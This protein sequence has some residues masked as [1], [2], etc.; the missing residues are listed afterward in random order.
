MEPFFLFSGFLLLAVTLFKSVYTKHWRS[1]QIYL[2]L[3]L[4]S[5]LH[6]SLTLTLLASGKIFDFPHF[7]RTGSIATYFFIPAS[8]LFV[9]K[10]IGKDKFRYT[11]LLFFIP[12]VIYLADMSRFISSDE[13]Y[14]YAQV[15]EDAKTGNLNGFRQSVFMPL[16]FHYYF[17][18]LF[19]VILSI[20]QIIFISKQLRRGGTEFFKENQKLVLWFYAWALMLMITCLPDLIMYLSGKQS[21]VLNY[22]YVSPFIFITYAYPISLLISPAVFNGIKGEW[23]EMQA[24]SGKKYRY[25]S[26][27]YL[28][29]SN[30]F[31][32]TKSAMD[33][34][35][36]AKSIT[37]SEYSNSDEQSN[38]RQNTKIYYS[39]EKAEILKNQIDQYMITM[40]PYL[41]IDYSINKLAVDTQLSVRQVSSLLNNYCNTSFKDYINGFRVKHFINKY[42]NEADSVKMTMEGL[43]KDSGFSNRYT[44]IHA[45]KKQMGL[46]PSEY[47]NRKTEEDADSKEQVSSAI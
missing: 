30:L 39:I 18:C 44:F 16:Q 46:P 38:G 4:L 19:G 24:G 47:L 35:G 20:L 29:N 8:F 33:E 37:G 21:D 40:R 17:K 10:S 27:L 28:A 22:W 36:S 3:S 13:L 14:K 11:D 32:T 23:L 2:I 15:S 5:L 42:M 34:E 31:D 41:D 7:Y 12:L 26:S 25:R 45:F 6:I 9:V 43:A 1:S